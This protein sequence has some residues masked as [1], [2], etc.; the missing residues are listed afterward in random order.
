MPLSMATHRPQVLE[1]FS[2][3]MAAKLGPGIVPILAL[4][5]QRRDPREVPYR[6]SPAGVR[7]SVPTFGVAPQDA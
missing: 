4:F 7:C 2:A 1:G 5:A 3:S 6:N